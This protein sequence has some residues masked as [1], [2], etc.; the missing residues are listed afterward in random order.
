MANR[1]SDRMQPD[2]TDDRSN[3]MDRDMGEDRTRGRADEDVR[4]GPAEEEEEFEETDELDEEDE[5]S[6]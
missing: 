4:G 6:R 5:E 2:R 1:E 3:R